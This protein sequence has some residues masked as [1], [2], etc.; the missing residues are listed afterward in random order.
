MSRIRADALT[1]KAGDDTRLLSCLRWDAVG[2]ARLATLDAGAWTELL[3]VVEAGLGQALL[4]RRLSRSAIAPPPAVAAALGRATKAMALRNMRGIA[5]LARALAPFD[6][7]VLLLKGVD[8]AQRVYG[9]LAQRRMSDID[10]LVHEQDAPACHAALIAAGYTTERAPGH[11]TL[12]DRHFKEANY[13]PPDRGGLPVD[14]HWRLTGPGFGAKLDL[15]GIWA[16]SQPSRILGPHSRVM[17]VEDLLL[18]LCDH[19]RHHSFDGPLTQLWDLAEIVEWAGSALD[20]E[21]FWQRAAAWHFERTVQLSFSQLE[22]DLGVT[23]PGARSP[24]AVTALLPTT[25]ANLG[26][27]PSHEG[28]NY[29][30][31]AIVF[32]ASAPLGTRLGLLLRALFPPAEEVGQ[33]LGTAPSRW[34]IYAAY[35]RYWL[36]KI[37]RRGTL[38]RGWLRRDPAIRGEL[39]RIEA[40]HAWLSAE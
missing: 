8:I 9:N 13:L 7:P 30:H 33:W 31:I 38:I 40:L 32:T 14:L 6:R 36:A 15:D 1:P 25:L 39:D 5:A 17:A 37:A 11:A 29:R 18:Y 23:V 3:S 22:R 28:L 24:A 2:D 4:A 21:V 19:I 20:W 27:H 35:P 12:G 34:R 26:L 10:I 16:R